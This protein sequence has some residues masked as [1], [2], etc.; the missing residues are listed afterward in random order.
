MAQEIKTHINAMLDDMIA[1]AATNDQIS[2]TEFELTIEVVES[3][4]SEAMDM[5][6]LFESFFKDIL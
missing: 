1:D 4:R 3:T 5:I 2:L 6:D